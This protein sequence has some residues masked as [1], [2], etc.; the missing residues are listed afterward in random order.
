MTTDTDYAGL[1]ADILAHPGDD[2]PRLILADWFDEHGQ[3][4]RAEFIHL[5]MSLALIEDQQCERCWLES[6]GMGYP[7]T[8]CTCSDRW[9]HLMSLQAKALTPGH[10]RDLVLPWIGDWRVCGN[11]IEVKPLGE[12]H[13]WWSSRGLHWWFMFSRGFVSEIRLPM[14]DWMQYGVDL[15]RHHPIE[16]VSS[17]DKSPWCVSATSDHKEFWMWISG[18]AGP[19]LDIHRLPRPVSAMLEGM[20]FDTD[21]QALDAL[22]NACLAWVKDQR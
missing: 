9:K 18:T 6:C 8:F 5:Q 2:T 22:S 13:K 19:N 20:S 1:M 10:I 4:E 17:S 15:V 11:V 7:K 21:Q 3:P 14:N 12:K 16:V